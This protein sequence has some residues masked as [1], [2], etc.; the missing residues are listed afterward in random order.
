VKTPATKIFFILVLSVFGLSGLK[1]DS[2]NVTQ[3]GPFVANS[4]N[5]EQIV[6]SNQ[7]LENIAQKPE[8]KENSSDF[9]FHF[10]NIFDVFRSLF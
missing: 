9:T 7:V 8:E 3:S 4:S 1:C 5:S 2:F 10:P 6:L